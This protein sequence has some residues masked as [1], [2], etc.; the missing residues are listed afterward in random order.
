V[1][2]ET[3]R[4]MR[5][6]LLQLAL[7]S[8]GGTL[9]YEGSSTGGERQPV[10][11]LSQHSAPALYWAHRYD[12]AEDDDARARALE[13]ARDELDHIRRSRGDPSKSET[14]TE[15][16]ARIVEDLEGIPLAE[17]AMRARCTISFARAAR[18]GAGRLEDSGKK[19][20]NGRELGA[21]LKDEIRR[22]VDAGASG[23]QVAK[24]LSISYDTVKRAVG[25][26]T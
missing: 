16:A 13:G 4:G 9:N 18:R 14:A 24:A 19:P 3:D 17:A 15:L 7:T 25:W 2:D 23:R 10:P 11:S 22:R 12:D 20:I 1:D 5:E 26:R 8:E 21:A 6:V